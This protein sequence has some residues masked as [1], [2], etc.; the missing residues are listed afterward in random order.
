MCGDTNRP[1]FGGTI[2]VLFPQDNRLSAERS[3][4]SSPESVISQST[5][6]STSS[7]SSYSLFFR[8]TSDRKT[9]AVFRIED[10]ETYQ[11][12]NSCDSL[13]IRIEKYGDLSTSSS[14]IA[15]L[16]QFLLDLS[17]NKHLKPDHQPT[18]MEFDLPEQLDLGVSEKGVV[19]RQVT[20]RESQGSI[21]GIGIVGY[22]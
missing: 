12:L 8:D 20:V 13:D 6:S 9:K 11:A 3:L 14:S 5:S 16:H 22:N 7:L 2:A 17:Q 4:S 1:T 10:L 15:P 21:L 18:E 19:G